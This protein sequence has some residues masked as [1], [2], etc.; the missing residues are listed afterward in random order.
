MCVGLYICELF[1]PIIKLILKCH[2]SYSVRVRSLISSNFIIHSLITLF[3]FTSL[4]NS[5]F[6]ETKN[7]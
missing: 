4:S 1:H 6:V 7:N 5:I 3:N 2:R